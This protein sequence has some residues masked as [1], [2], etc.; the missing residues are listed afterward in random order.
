MSRSTLAAWVTAAV[1][2][3]FPTWELWRERLGYEEFVRTSGEPDT[4]YGVVCRFGS[5]TTLSPL[6]PLSHDLEAI[7]GFATEW[8]VAALVVLLGLL[9]CLNRGDPGATGR[10]VA[11]LLVM[12]AAVGPL[13]SLYGYSEIC[14]EEIPLLSVERLAA[15][16]N[17]WGITQLCLLMAAALVFA[18]SWER[19]PD[20]SSAGMAWRRPAAV[21]VD[22]LVI[23]TVLSVVVGL[24][25]GVGPTSGM[26]VGFLKRV[27]VYPTAP[28]VP[29]GLFLYF[30]VQHVLWGR[31]PGKWLLGIRVVAAGTR[32]SAGRAALR[33]L[34]F[35]LLA[36]VPG[37][38]LWLLL[39]DGLWTLF[40]AE[41]R[42]LR[43]RLLGFTVI[44]D[45]SI[46]GVAA[47]GAGGGV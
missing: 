40:D 33:A 10:R 32:S 26:G 37:A 8:A 22:Y 43:D 46:P 25:I 31:T 21:L 36:L 5:G 17:G 34:A 38:G 2:A 11:W 30:W 13:T 7:G 42:V 4:F 14:R 1:V 15:M 6:A 24:V 27:E 16:A 9:S 47:P 18:S 44:R 12:G 41:G 20:G 19:H 39:V 45:R 23:C 28:A 29:A 3:A 35:P